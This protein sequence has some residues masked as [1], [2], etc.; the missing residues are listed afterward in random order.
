MGKEN[1][2]R[3]GKQKVEVERNEDDN[4]ALKMGAPILTFRALIRPR[5]S[6]RKD[7][8]LPLKTKPH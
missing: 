8:S 3:L 5:K 7:P 6:R 2:K 1:T 4:G